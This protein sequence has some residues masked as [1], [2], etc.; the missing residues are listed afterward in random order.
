MSEPEEESLDSI[1]IPID[2]LQVALQSSP[3]SDAAATG[4]SVTQAMRVHR[5]KKR[6][7]STALRA[8]QPRAT[9]VAPWSDASF[10]TVV[11]LLFTVPIAFQ[12]IRDGKTVAALFM[13]F[14]VAGATFTCV[15]L[16]SRALDR[17][18]NS[19]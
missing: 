18:V 9:Y 13:T 15:S 16:L 2:G 17:S 10:P 8:Y 6:R 14:G 3:L 4:L 19:G 12:W 11:S 5:S 1:R 7:G